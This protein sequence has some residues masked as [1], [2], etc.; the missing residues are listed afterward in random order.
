MSIVSLITEDKQI[1]ALKRYCEAERS[2]P[3]AM[4]RG[5]MHI[6]RG[7]CNPCTKSDMRWFW[8][9]ERGTAHAVDIGGDPG[10]D[11]C[12]DATPQSGVGWV[13]IRRM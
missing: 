11:G 1:A 9:D 5:L 6:S 8:R 3:F 12:Y 10:S 2:D 7:L 13:N 4:A